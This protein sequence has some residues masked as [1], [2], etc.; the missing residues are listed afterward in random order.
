MPTIRSLFDQN[1]TLDRQIEKV[2]TYSRDQKDHLAA[3]ISEYVVTDHIDKAYVKLLKLMQDSLDGRQ[4]EIG[5]WVS[6]F[7]G[8][9]KSSFSKYLGFALDAE[10]KIGDKMF[11]DYLKERLRSSEA[12]VLL[13]NVSSRFNPQ[14]I[15][16]DLGV[17]QIAGNTTMPVSD[18]LYTKVQQWAGYSTDPRIADFE[19]KIEKDGKKAEFEAD[20]F[21]IYKDTWANLKSVP[22]MALPVASQLAHKYYPSI[23]RTPEQLSSQLFNELVSEEDRVAQMIDLIR[24]RSGRENI[25]FVIDEAGHYV[26]AR[27]ELILNLDGLARNI[28]NVGQGKV[29]LVATAQQILAENAAALNSENL[30]KLKDRFPID[31]H[32]ESSDIREICYRRLLTKSDVATADL[33]RRYEENAGNIRL[34][35]A[36]ENAGD[37]SAAIDVDSFV[38]LYPFPPAQFEILVRLLGRLARKTGGVGLRSTIKI[39]QDILT[40]PP[41]PLADKEVGYLANA[42]SLYDSLRIE[43]GN[44]FP[45]INIGI[46][47]VTNQFP[48]KELHLKVAKAIAILQVLDSMTTT[49]KNLAAVLQ[50]DL[51]CPTALGQQVAAVLEDFSRN[52]FIPI[53]PAQGNSYKFLSTEG[54]NLQQ[55]F[56]R[57]EVTVAS[58]NQTLNLAV[59]KAF[60]DELP[61]AQIYQ[62]KSIKAG[63]KVANR[64]SQPISIEG[65]NESVQ[66]VVQ[67]ENPTQ[68]ANAISGAISVSIQP[69]H[70]NELFLVAERT[71]DHFENAKIYTQCEEFLRRHTGAATSELQEFI[72]I[73]KHRQENAELELL[74]SYRR[75]FSAAPVIAAG[76]DHALDSALPLNEALSKVLSAAGKIIFNKYPLVGQSIASA[77]AERLLA[78]NLDAVAVEADPL[79][80]VRRTGGVAEVNHGH[81]ALAA[82]F[83]FLNAHGRIDGGTV[84][85]EFKN[86][87]YGWTPDTVRYLLAALLQAGKIQLIINNSTHATASDE[88]RR[89]LANSQGLSNI[90]IEIRSN[91]PS[92]ELRGKAA[93]RLSELLG[94]TIP[95]QERNIGDTVIKKIPVLQQKLSLF[96]GNLAYLNLA[97]VKRVQT[98]MQQLS[99]LVV[100]DG[101]SAISTL[102]AEQSTTY[103]NTKWARDLQLVLTNDVQSV[104]TLAKEIESLNLASVSELSTETP[105]LNE[106]LAPYIKALLDELG[107]FNVADLVNG[108]TKLEDIILRMTA[109]LKQYDLDERTNI[110]SYFQHMYEWS[111]VLDNEERAQIESMVR[112]QPSSAT[113]GLE[114]LR[115]W[116]QAGVIRAQ[117]Q[118]AAN[119]ALRQYVNAKAP[120]SNTPVG[121]IIPVPP[122]LPVPPSAPEVDF[123]L[124]CPAIVRSAEDVYGLQSQFNELG[125]LLK[126]SPVRLKIKQLP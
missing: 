124:T 111:V 118:N 94:I 13:T 54:T 60:N 25:L 41:A 79:G 33:K 109:K 120:K 62:G 74:K 65:Q 19:L 91:A 59:K 26:S 57:L 113:I 114:G 1:R 21:T 16:L 4:S 47:A 48:G 78:A 66:L 6:G 71:P 110:I 7:Y 28:K 18:V 73:I 99:D 11:R 44:S 61:F 9:G 40:A 76:E 104:L 108:R 32:L 103:T 2:I 90:G 17:D 87:P 14:V 46:E 117:N 72:K 27:D 50:S 51:T 35:T 42:V 45:H 34:N 36:L 55:A 119:K 101:S 68:L 24:R 88:A 97:C 84:I 53:Q 43:I 20:V 31:V 70:R 69:A 39:L 8:S 29:W 49:P 77:C 106:I 122:A 15:L 115:Y 85:N 86:Q 105:E 30:Y 58:V 112:V 107:N 123:E 121:T 56:D 96:A 81:S 10:R 116:L 95:P 67:F 82:V 37:L 52:N 38:N 93:A 92:A 89:A 63:L 100:G 64:G 23:F 3:E 83:D 98:A 80:L 5:V 22:F 75:V 102:G 125:R 12:K 126:T